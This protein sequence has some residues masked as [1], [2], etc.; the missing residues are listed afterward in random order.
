MNIK[1]KERMK[2]IRGILGGIF[3]SVILFFLCGELFFREKDPALDGESTLYEG[4]WERVFA[5]GTR[6]AVT[7]PGK[8]DV[9]IGEVVRIETTLPTNQTDTWFCMR[10]SQE[11]MKV[12]V[13]GELRTEY[14]TEG[15]RPFGKTSASA[16]VF[17]RIY[18]TDAGKTLAVELVSDSTY[19]GLMNEVYTGDKHD[20]WRGF[21]RECSLV[22]FVSLFML[23]V[24]FVVVVAGQILRIVYKKHVDIS[25]LGLGTM[26]ISLAMISES[27]VRQ[28]F[29]PSQTV[30]AIVGLL[31][32][33]LVPY[34]F[35]AYMD[36]LQK[37]RYEKVYFVVEVCI[38]INFVVS[39][40]LQV[41]NVKDFIDTMVIAY[42][43]IVL[44]VVVVAVT[45]G[46]DVK[47][48][49][50]REYKE[51][52]IGLIAMMVVAIWETCLT[53]MP[54]MG[55]NGGV[56]LSIGLIILL[57]MAAF[58]TGRDMIAIEREKQEAILAGVSK[59]RFLANMSHEIR[60]PINTIIGMNEMILREN[61]D[62]AI[63]EYAQNVE[64]ASKLLLG[65]INDVLDF[66]KIEAGRM[67]I[68]ENEYHVSTLL[69]DVSQGIRL[70]AESKNLKMKV[71]IEESLPSV[72][73]GDEIRIRQILN[74]LLSNAVKYTLEGTVM[75]SVRGIRS[76]EGFAL[77]M[78]VSDTGIGIRKTDIDRLF[79]SFT[80]LEEKKNRYIE[81]TGLGLNITRQLVELMGGTIH[82]QSEYGKGSDF[83]VVIPQQVI[84][85]TPIGNIRDAYKRDKEKIQAE[86]MGLF[87]QEA[88][89]LVVDDNHMNIEVIKALLKRTGIRIDTAGGGKEC[90]ELCRKKKYDLI[91]MD[92]MMPDPDGIETMH[93]LRKDTESKNRDV[94]IIVLTANALAGM[95]EKYLAEGFTDYVSKPIVAEVLEKVLYKHLP[96]EKMEVSTQM[97]LSFTAGNE[98]IAPAID[99]AAGLAY[100]DHD[101]DMYKEMLKIYEKQ[102]RPYILQIQECFETGDWKNLQ[103]IAHAIK[104]TSLM[105]GATEM[106]EAAKEIETAAKEENVKI[107][108]ASKENFVKSYEE[109]LNAIEKD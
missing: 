74:N 31:L 67:D 107:L 103:I 41:L 60:T 98:V 12:Y 22:L 44:M 108:M 26:L 82:V 65:L 101:E 75:L 42:G 96:K 39:V 109:V 8:C 76:E 29:L 15:I 16:Y 34:P 55:Q 23:V 1:E 21:F 52:I 83:T 102:G 63:K 59:T 37:K 38:L 19:G 85:E 78:S 24:S 6:E 18:D 43:L 62:D 90:L 33:M 93:L 58:K 2:P 20:I 95:Q 47:N 28:F 30:A 87:A 72:L 48:G 68:L 91:L 89:I 32:T 46:I 64:D 84:D 10:S 80:R 3:L 66:S 92:H 61:R 49:K 99:R 94:K 57:F 56:A 81:G 14:S 50:V 54:G 40:A 4:L 45:I 100:C 9:A 69:S 25:Y 77:K 17:F 5:D 105:I 106:S 13:D 88:E 51:I 73:K 11:D 86:K 97:E 104:S 79:G 35:L 70:K 71:M 7:V 53:F 27:R 36:R